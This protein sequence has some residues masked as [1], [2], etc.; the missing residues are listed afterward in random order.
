MTS[1]EQ[2]AISTVIV[3]LMQGVVYREVH[4]DDWRTIERHEARVQDHFATIGIRMIVD[5]T[6]GYAYLKTVEPSDDEEPLPRLVKRRALTYPVSLL[7]LLLRKRLAEFEAGGD[8]GKLV[9]ERDQIVEML[10][11]FLRDSTNEARILKQVDQTITKVVELG[12]LHK[13]RGSQGRGAWEV[14]RILK[15]Y[16]DVETMADF[17]GK[18]E[19]YAQSE[20]GPDAETGADA[21][22]AEPETGPDA[23][24]A[25]LSLLEEPDHE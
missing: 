3:K 15:A 23:S 9:L 19:A 11:I 14:R 20:A 21:S 17:A 24:A 2:H 6:E 4:E 13:L 5:Q 1:T 22:A 7:L 10:R 8:E 12:F 25:E 16:V 18:L